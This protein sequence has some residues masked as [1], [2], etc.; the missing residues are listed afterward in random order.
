[1]PGPSLSAVTV[2]PC[3]STRPFTSAS[4]IPS[5]PVE[6]SM[7]RSTWENMSKIRGKS[8]AGMPIPVS[9][10]EMTTSSSRRSAVSQM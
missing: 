4:P 7:L 2:P 8:S 5:P 6:R 9:R 10:T 3:I 1:M